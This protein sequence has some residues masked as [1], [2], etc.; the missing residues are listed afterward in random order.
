MRFIVFGDFGAT[1]NPTRFSGSGVLRVLP[2]GTML[3][4]R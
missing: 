3:L 1:S 2:K 4:S